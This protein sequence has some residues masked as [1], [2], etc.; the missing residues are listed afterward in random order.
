MLYNYIFRQ[1]KITFF[2]KIQ[3]YVTYNN[4]QYYYIFIKIYDSQF[5]QAHF[6]YYNPITDIFPC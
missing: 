2:Y 4:I 5:Y 1:I 6:F 3:N